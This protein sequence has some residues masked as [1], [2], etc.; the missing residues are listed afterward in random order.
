MQRTI[1]N[2]FHL[3]SYGHNLDIAADSQSL[4][5]VVFVVTVV[6]PSMR[7][8]FGWTL[9][10]LTSPYISVDSDLNNTWLFQ[11][12]QVL[13]WLC[14]RGSS[15]RDEEGDKHDLAQVLSCTKG[16]IADRTVLPFLYVHSIGEPDKLNILS[17]ELE[18]FYLKP[19]SLS[20]Q[21]SGKD[22]C[23]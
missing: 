2:C 14:G 18:Q 23:K 8:G 5:E 19:R 22:F 16:H 10:M 20:E 4:W 21:L 9:R 1:T 6:V 17:L 7:T 3:C 15:H 13:W 12:P 11:R